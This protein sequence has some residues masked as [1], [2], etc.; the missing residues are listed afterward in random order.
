MSRTP[1]YTFWI[2][3]DGDGVCY[4][5]VDRFPTPEAFLTRRY[6]LSYAEDEGHA[7]YNDWKA[8][9]PLAAFLVSEAPKVTR[10]WY[11][12]RFCEDNGLSPEVS[13]QGKRGAFELWEYEG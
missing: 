13:A 6:N 8:E 11:C 2:P 7:Y 5:R 12:W 1:K 4:G 10:G 9:H 3:D